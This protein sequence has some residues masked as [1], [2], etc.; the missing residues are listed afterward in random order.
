MRR[1]E[2]PEPLAFTIS[3]FCERHNISR[4]LFYNLLEQGRAPELMRVGSKP[5]VSVE[6][7]AAW[8][9]RMAQG[10]MNG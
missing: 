9:K 10:A 4:R 1:S 8:R 5:L 6:A 7:A 3:G 2:K